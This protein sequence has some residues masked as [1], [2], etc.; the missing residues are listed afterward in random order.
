MKMYENGNDKAQGHRAAASAW[1]CV[2][3]TVYGN[4]NVHF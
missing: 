4:S 1:A 2:R 3:H